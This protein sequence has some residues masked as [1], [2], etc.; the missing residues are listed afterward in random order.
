M[1]PSKLVTTALAALLL[2]T[3]LSIGHALP[4]ASAV[5]MND[6]AAATSGDA[7]SVEPSPRYFV[8]P[9]PTRSG[10]RVHYPAE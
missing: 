2:A 4:R 10:C 7:R 5:Q 3:P 8:C 1:D 9:A 6:S